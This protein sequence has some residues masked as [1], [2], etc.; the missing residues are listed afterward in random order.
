MKK[1]NT[2]SIHFPKE[3][4]ILSE[5]LPFEIPITFSNKSF[6]DFII[7][8]N[9]QFSI[10]DNEISWRYVSDLLDSYISLILGLSSY[11]FEEDRGE[12]IK[13]RRIKIRK[14]QKHGKFYTIPYS[15]KIRNKP[16]SYRDLSIMHPLNQIMWIAFYE[17]YKDLIIKLSNKSVA[18]LRKPVRVAGC[19][20]IDR[21]SYIENYF[22]DNE[23]IEL[24][25]QDHPNLKSY[26]IYKRYRN[27]YEFFESDLHISSE[28][29]FSQLTK[30][31]ITKCFPSIYTHSFTWATTSKEHAKGSI[32]ESSQSF[33]SIFDSFMQRCNYNETSG[34]LVGPEVSRIFS[35]I[36][37]QAV[38]NSLI[39]RC[40]RHS[41]KYGVDY[42]FFRYVDDIFVF[43]NYE[44]TRNIFIEELQLSLD[45]FKLH[46]NTNKIEHLS[47]PIITPISV[48]KQKISNFLSDFV[49][50][51]TNENGQDYLYISLKELATRFKT[52]LFESNVTYA[53]ISNFTT[54]ILESQIKSIL[55]RV[56]KNKESFQNK[57]VIYSLC[58][59]LDF[60]FFVYSGNSNVNSSIKIS[61]IVKIILDFLKAINLSRDESYVVKLNVYNNV[62]DV[63]RSGLDTRA[64]YIE[65]MYLLVILK[66]LG[67]GFWIPKE[68]LRKFIGIKS[69]NVIEF[70]RR[71]QYFYFTCL[72]Y[73]ISDKSE[74]EDIKLAALNAINTRISELDKR[75]A[76]S[77]EK[78]L[79]TIDMINYPFI[80]KKTKVSIFSSIPNMGELSV[81]ANADPIGFTTWKNLDLAKALD[82]KKGLDVY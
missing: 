12:K 58:S 80:D 6:F 22:T 82:H 66:E 2:L 55:S 56:K 48:A 27:I 1:K 8:Y 61:R 70:P 26:F 38:D 79:M 47:R 44:S 67:K 42:Q 34:I 30:L 51:K 14:N 60:S 16:D 46:L 24:D 4:V 50:V 18:S 74:Y 49:K 45:E 64:E 37:L 40:E 68:S 35:E 21:R 29:K 20:Y 5:I 81:A 33:S 72:L 76:P 25:K 3:R 15:Y 19:K 13:L 71:A 31:D 23:T 7:K 63:L 10:V 11:K 59:L 57:R 78:V 41:L 77:T 69:E 28:K 62:L 17:K 39:K 65:T 75:N 43:Y 9:I 36:I 52:I 53:D 54:T 32:S 73:Y